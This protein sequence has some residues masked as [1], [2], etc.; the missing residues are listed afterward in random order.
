MSPRLSAVLLA[1]AV[2]L[3][4][5][6]TA[7]TETTQ[8]PRV[9]AARVWGLV[10][11]HHPRIT[12]CQVNWDIALRQ[13][14]PG[15]EAADPQ[16]ADE[17]IDALLARAGG[18]QRLP[19]DAATPDW[20]AAAPLSQALREQLNWLAA[21][22]PT[23]QCYVSATPGLPAQFGSD[24]GQSTPIPDR[25]TRALAAL[26]FWNA[27]EY[28]FPYKEEIGRDWAEVLAEHLPLILDAEPGLPYA[29]QMRRLVA[30]IRDSHGFFYHPGSI[31]EQGI[32]TP[33]LRMREIEGRNIVVE[34]LPVESPVRPGDE[35]LR[36][37]GE[38][39]EA[40]IARLDAVAG[41]GSNPVWR[42][43]QM[44]RLALR[45]TDN[46][47]PV[48]LRRPDGSEYETTLPRAFGF[49]ITEPPPPR[50]QIR[51]LPQGCRIGV[52]DLVQVYPEDVATMLDELADTDA[53]LIDIRNYPPNPSFTMVEHLFETPRAVSR[54]GAPD[55]SRPGHYLPYEVRLGG[56]L[57]SGYRGRLLLLQDEESMSHAEYSLMLLQA[58]G[59]A[60]S[61]GSQTAAADGNIT[62]MYLPGD[63][64][65]YFTG[66]S[67][68]Y[69]DGRPTQRIGIVPDVHVT[70]T[71]A[72]VAAGRD[73]VMEA[74]LDCRWVEQTPPPRRP[75]QGLY[76]DPAHADQGLDVHYDASGNIAVT[77]YGYDD[78][79]QP[80]WLLSAGPAAAEDWR[81]SFSR[82]VDGQYDA[83]LPGHDLDFHRGP[84]EV[85][86]AISDQSR[87]LP[88]ARWRQPSAAGG[89]EHCV[90]PLILAGQQGASGAWG[91]D[92]SGWGVSLHHRDGFIAAIVYAYD[93]DGQP[94][95][96]L[97]LNEDWDGIAPV[98]F[99][100][101]RA[102][103]RCA[104]CAAG[105]GAFT[106]AGVMTLDLSGLHSGQAEDNRLWIDAAFGPGPRW[107]REDVRIERLTRT[108][109]GE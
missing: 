56:S 23:G 9:L 54:L 94:R 75:P 42:K 29:T 25:P 10:K 6:A 2:L 86:C 7:G 65:V 73:E 33:P 90:T 92:E 40:R 3:Q 24:R 58:G 51:Q 14:W 77:R 62:W 79:G 12:A 48:R 104:G 63:L 45:G 96:L 52:I 83:L 98:E 37:D 50:W 21:Q 80:R 1:F 89:D 71:I 95:W 35:L 105:D 8:D 103:P 81:Q 49:P 22:R 97:G 32:G 30:E 61:F 47:V 16:A 68:H 66:L 57:Y 93:N 55:L 18:A 26:R 87:L 27:I 11:Y 69:P 5:P 106:P 72:G 100:L 82:Y 74:A 108:P 31:A 13:V 101:L 84:Y 17:A 28:F 34:K 64:E 41:W 38:D 4:A 109:G 88:R 46:P 43:Q 15:I 85:A 20:I 76:A 102:A 36:L 91:T 67:V 44:R 78:D 19:L 39:F 60:I 99:D 59:R 53:L 107:R 70:R